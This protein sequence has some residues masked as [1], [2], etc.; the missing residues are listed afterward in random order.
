MMRMTLKMMMTRMRMMTMMKT[1]DMFTEA[2]PSRELEKQHN[3]LKVALRQAQRRIPQSARTR[4]AV[5]HVL[6]S[7]ECRLTWRFF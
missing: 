3:L 4:Y 6:K 7:K 2:A 5:P 1:M